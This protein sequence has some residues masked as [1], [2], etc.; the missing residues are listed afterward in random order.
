MRRST[1][2]SHGIVTD[3]HDSNHKSE[4]KTYS[5]RRNT[6]LFL[7]KL[8]NNQ[9][10]EIPDINDAN[11]RSFTDGIGKISPEALRQV[12][13]TLLQYKTV[14]ILFLFYFIGIV[15]Y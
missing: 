3:R 1:N 8:Q 12:S 11:D 14:N 15:C 9:I 5:N 7:F 4:S 2:R 13:E 10:E 6:N